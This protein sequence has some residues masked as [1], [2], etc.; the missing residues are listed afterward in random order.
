M[1]FCHVLFFLLSLKIRVKM[2]GQPFYLLP[3]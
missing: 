3:L 2:L 1:Y